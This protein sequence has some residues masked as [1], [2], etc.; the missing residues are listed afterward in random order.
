M[1]KS[2]WSPKDIK[3]KRSTETGN[4]AVDVRAAQSGSSADR[5]STTALSS[6]AASTSKLERTPMAAVGNDANSGKVPDVAPAAMGDA[7]AGH[8]R[9]RRRRVSVDG[10]DAVDVH[11]GGRVRLIRTLRG[12]SQT[13]LG[14]E[15][16]LTFQQ[17]QKYERGMNRI[18][19]STLFRLSRT[20]DVPISFFF[21]DMAPELGQAGSG[22]DIP[23]DSRRS[24]LSTMRALGNISDPQVRDA[25]NNL[26]KVLAS[27]LDGNGQD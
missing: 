16:G 10:P 17:V 26:A 19:A 1:A 3:E 23:A 7:E 12:M 8:R 13:D 14:N 2:N 5:L 4:V 24:T 9:R 21:D 18:S 27:N 15:I 11:V 25:L 22:E 6:G 20:F